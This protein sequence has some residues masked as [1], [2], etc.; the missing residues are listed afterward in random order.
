MNFLVDLSLL[1][2]ANGRDG[3][4]RAEAALVRLEAAHR[5]HPSRLRRALL[6]AGQVLA[7][8]HQLRSAPALCVLSR[9]D[10]ADRGSGQALQTV[11]FKAALLIAQFAPLDAVSAGEVI[12][13][14][15]SVDWTSIGLTGSGDPPP[16]FP[17]DAQL[18]PVARWIH[19]GGPC[20]LLAFG[21]L[22]SL[23]SRQA[24]LRSTG[25]V[26]P[27]LKWDRADATG[28]SR[29]WARTRARSVS[30]SARS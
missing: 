5:R 9:S 3:A 6:H 14:G 16:T 19:F 15:A 12:D 23:S 10:V 13:L 4:D 1:E 11:P 25:D 28:S 29:P 18:T 8:V 2:A 7:I 17:E 26:R 30:C 27:T 21:T 24:I 22:D 20:R